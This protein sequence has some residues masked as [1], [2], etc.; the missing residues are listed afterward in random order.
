MGV[1]CLIISVTVL[2]KLDVLRIFLK[3]NPRLLS[4]SSI[5]CEFY[6]IFNQNWRESGQK[7]STGYLHESKEFHIRTWLLSTDTRDELSARL[8]RPRKSIHDRIFATRTSLN[9][10]YVER[11]VSEKLNKCDFKNIK[12]NSLPRWWVQNF[13]IFL[14]GIHWLNVSDDDV[15]F[16]H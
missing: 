14:S 3:R 5:N 11:C 15:R 12:K 7:L 9:I 8:L 6:F 1:V 13:F 10:Y 4:T 16:F 2:D